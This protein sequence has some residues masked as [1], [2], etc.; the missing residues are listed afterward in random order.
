MKPSDSIPSPGNNGQQAHFSDNSSMHEQ[1]LPTSQPPQ[2]SVGDRELDGS[3][4]GPNEV[5]SLG[6]SLNATL[7]FV[8]ESNE[9]ELDGIVDGDELGWLDGSN[10]GELDGVVD[11]DKLG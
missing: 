3:V 2:E 6:A 7:G 10:E 9:G 11:G 4:L 1:N 8:E 5:T